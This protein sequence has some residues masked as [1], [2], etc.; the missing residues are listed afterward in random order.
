[1]STIYVNKIIESDFETINDLQNLFYK[2]TYKGIVLG[3]RFGDKLATV[4]QKKVYKG[5][6][7]WLISYGKDLK[8]GYISESK[9]TQPSKF[10]TSLLCSANYTVETL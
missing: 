6:S 5:V 1:M 8:K 9:A 3:V 2:H 4:E 7:G 10:T